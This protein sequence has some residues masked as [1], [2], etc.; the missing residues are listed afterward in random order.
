M[1]PHCPSCKRIERKYPGDCVD[2]WHQ[3]PPKEA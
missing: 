1:T 3:K 2:P